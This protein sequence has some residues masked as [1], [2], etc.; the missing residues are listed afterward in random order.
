M[1]MLSVIP[2]LILAGLIPATIAKRKGANFLKFWFFGSLLFVFVLPYAMA[3]EPSAEATADRAERGDRAAVARGDA[4]CAACRD[5]MRAGLTFCP[6]CRTP[7]Q[8]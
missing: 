7:V 5:F 8:P 1:V 4:R 6:H 3:M 2:I